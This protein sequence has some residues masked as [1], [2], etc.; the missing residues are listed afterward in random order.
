M[1]AAGSM[2]VVSSTPGGTTLILGMSSLLA[3]PLSS[4]GPTPVGRAVQL[5]LSSALAPVPARAVTRFGVGCSMTLR[6]FSRTML[7][8]HNNWWRLVPYCLGLLP[9]A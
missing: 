7:H 5:L 1:S 9:P 3:T 2:P 4:L 8:Y 6:T